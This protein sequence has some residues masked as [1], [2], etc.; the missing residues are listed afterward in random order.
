MSEMIER[1][2]LAMWQRRELTNPGFTRRMTPDDIDRATGAW[3]GMVDLAHAAIEAMR[4]PTDA[5]LVAGRDA[6]FERTSLGQLHAH[7]AMIDEALKP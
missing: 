1:V 4:E 7:R 5:M 2:A 6:A 3:A